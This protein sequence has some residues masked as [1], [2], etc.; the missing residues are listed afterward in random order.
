MMNKSKTPVRKLTKY[1]SIIPLAL[2]FISV[3]SIYAAQNVVEIEEINSDN[4][5]LQN[6]PPARR[7]VHVGEIFIEV[8]DEPE[9]PGGSG[10]MMK[11]I[12]D[13]LK[14]PVEA[15]KNGIQGRVIC[16]MVI[17]KD[18]SIVNVEVE[19]GVD[20]LLD[21]EAVRILETMPNWIPG[22]QRGNAVNV[23]YTLPLVFRLSSNNHGVINFDVSDDMK[24]VVITTDVNS[25]SKDDTFDELTLPVEEAPQ[26][27]GG[28]DALM[29]YL[30]DNIVYPVSAQMNGVQ[31]RVICSMLI[32]KDGSISD[33]QIVRGV[34][35]SI[36]NEAVRVIESMPNWI[37]GK[38]RG[39]AVSVRWTLP[40]VF[41]LQGGDTSNTV[42]PEFPGGNHALMKY[43]GEN[44]KYPVI[45]QEQNIQGLIRVVYNID[46][47]GKASIADN[48]L[49]GDEILTKEVRRII[50]SMPAWKPAYKDGKAIG[51]A[52]MAAFV[53][54]LQ[55]DDGSDFKSYD[56][57][58]PEDAVVI[59]GYATSKK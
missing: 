12:A 32:G 11:Y 45:A 18:G 49:S 1:L 54:R 38:Q 42:S 30:G 6:P 43:L 59:V 41:R 5:E 44:I 40:V 26:F 53:F 46:E 34:D 55:G 39:N 7:N 4:A 37:P 8:Q 16:K 48:G 20:P 47:N 13:N 28:T 57:E 19:K 23:R 9:F 2:L 22:K 14:Y 35:S 3:N 51:S 29:K 56:G 52:Q 33:V 17:L 50:E 36:D 27:P 31:G 24:E 10:A 25:D 15:I 58:L 21:A